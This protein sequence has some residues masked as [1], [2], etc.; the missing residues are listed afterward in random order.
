MALGTLLDQAIKKFHD[1]NAYGCEVDYI[2]NIVKA[3]AN[4]IRED[5]DRKPKPSFY[6]AVVPFLTDDLIERASVIFKDYYQGL[7]KT[8]ER[9][10]GKVGFCEWVIEPEADATSHQSYKVWGGPDAFELRGN[11]QAEIVDYKSREDA[12]KG[13]ER[14]DMDLMPKL[15]TLLSINYLLAKGYNSARFIVR[16]WQLPGDD[17]LSEE[18]DFSEAKSLEEIFRGKIKEIVE[19]DK[20]SFCE[21]KFCKACQ[22]PDRGKY[23]YQLEKFGIVEAGLKEAS[24]ELPF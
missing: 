15:Y 13:K 21:K 24:S 2:P 11:G 12:E 7:N 14:M 20:V 10:I 9:S 19:T 3:G 23:L 6:S 17:S 8:I 18:F 16:L 4:F 22:S 5:E 1:S